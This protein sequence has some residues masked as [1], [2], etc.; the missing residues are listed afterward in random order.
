LTKNTGG[1]VFCKGERLVS[2]TYAERKDM[3]K[4]RVSGDRETKKVIG[5]F[6]KMRRLQK[7]ISFL[8]SLVLTLGLCIATVPG[9]VKA[10]EG[11]QFTVTA[12]K[13]EL[14]RGDTVNV[15]VSMKGNT[16]G[17]GLTYELVFDSSKLKPEDPVPGDVF[18]GLGGQAPNKAFDGQSIVAAPLDLAGGI[19]RDG[20]LMTVTFQVLDTA[21]TGETGFHS[22]I[23]VVAQSGESVPVA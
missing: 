18:N 6:S 7:T 16:Q 23:N 9:E 2:G 17:Q 21:D 13:T 10:A 3:E 12:D 15:T 19:L 8:L 5:G 11:V 1:G 4:A 22:E 20:S 14:Q